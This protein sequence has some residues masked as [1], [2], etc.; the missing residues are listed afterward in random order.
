MAAITHS[1]GPELEELD[2]SMSA[3]QKSKEYGSK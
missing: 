3:D 1:T 2:R